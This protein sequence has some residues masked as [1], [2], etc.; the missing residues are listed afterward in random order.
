MKNVTKTI[1]KHTAETELLHHRTPGMT[2]YASPKEPSEELFRT[3]CDSSP[4]G[5]YIAQDKRLQ[6]VNPKFQ[7]LAGF[8]ES[9]LL[10]TNPMELILPADKAAVRTNAIAMLKGKRTQPYEYRVSNRA[11]AS[12]AL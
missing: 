6:Y 12:G 2:Q 8:T 7:E 5:V 9:E 10:D 11:G 3:L 4:I 1:E